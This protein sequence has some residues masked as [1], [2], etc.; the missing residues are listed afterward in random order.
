MLQAV[1]QKLGMEKAA[2]MTVLVAALGYFVDVFDLILF[3]I[4]RVQSLKDIGLSGD[5]LLDDGV[6]I[7]NCQM[8]GLLLGGILWGVLGDKLGR[9]K[10]LFGSIALYS[11]ANLLN[12]FV[13]TVDQYAILRFLAG[14]GLA[15]ELGAGITLAS[16]LMP[17]AIRGWGTTFV[18]LIGLLGGAT[19]ALVADQIDWRH[20]YI[21][22]GTMGFA[23]LILRLKVQESHLFEKSD[24]AEAGLRGNILIILR[25]PDLLKRFLLLVMVGAPIWFVVGVLITFS[26]EF[27]KAFNMPSL[28]STGTAVLLC[29]LGFAG[30]DILSG[31]LSQHFKSRRVAV[32]SFLA[33][34]VM[35]ILVH[36]KISG[37]SLTTF[38]TMCAVLG[39]CSGY[40]AMLVQIA[41]E[42]FGTN[43][44]ATVTTSVPNF[45]R[46]TAVLSVSGFHAL[47]P[48]FGVIQAG[49]M[50][51]GVVITLALLAMTQVKETFGRDLDFIDR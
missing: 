31:F 12:G 14:I 38:Y 24:H 39:F 46:G 4:V 36:L 41:A 16:E 33:M 32:L 9:I 44:R 10:V 20:A 11:T 17:K 1:S 2:I 23:L 43:L 42:Q 37:H 29:Y 7:I 3:S 48:D 6:F 8:T 40:W 45:V 26:P 50:V 19:A 22:G 21:F 5:Q 25:R 13:T 18:G 35:A 51:A 28:P 30:G 47:V 15:G 49:L 34:T 27:A